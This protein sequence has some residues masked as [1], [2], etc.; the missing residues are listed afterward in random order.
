MSVQRGE[1]YFMDLDPVKGREQGGTRPVLVVS[2][3]S[4][5]ALPLVITVVPGTKGTHVLH[6]FRTNVRVPPDDS[7]LPEETVFLCFQIRA[8]DSSRFPS[9]P[10]GVLSTRAMKTINRTLRHCLGI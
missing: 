8:V 9:R 5:N 7:G 6:D 4:I 10:A 2:V 1:I 3:D